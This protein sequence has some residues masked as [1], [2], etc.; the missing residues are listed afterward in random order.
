M[1]FSDS[2]LLLTGQQWFLAGFL[3]GRSLFSDLPAD[4]SLYRIQ[5]PTKDRRHPRQVVGRQ[6]EEGLCLH[7][8][9]SDEMGFAKP[10]DGLRPA[11][12]FFDALSD[13]QTDRVARMPGGSPINGAVRLLGHVGVSVYL[14]ALLPDG[15]R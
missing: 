1:T 5:P 9:Q 8:G 10:A 2:A 11:E 6:S 12:Y 13:L 15:Q 3:S 14:S 4:F 7:L